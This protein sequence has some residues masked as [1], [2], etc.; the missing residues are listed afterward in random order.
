MGIVNIDPRVLER[1][2]LAEGQYGQGL[3]HEADVELTGFEFPAVEN[4]PAYDPVGARGP[5][6]YFGFKVV[7]ADGK[8]LWPEEWVE[9]GEGSGRKIQDFLSAAG[10]DLTDDGKGGFNFDN[11]SV[12]PRKVNGIQMAAPRA[13]KT[14]GTMFNGKVMAIIG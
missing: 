12:A 2:V 7:K 1:P 8:T 10:V 5:Y 6:A 3:Q 4:L 9:I 11:T 14:T 13:S